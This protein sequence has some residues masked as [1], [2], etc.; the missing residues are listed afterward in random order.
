[1]KYRRHTD[2][3]KKKASENNGKY[4]LGKT[5]SRDSVEKMRLTK[6]GKKASE[7][8]KIKMGKS[9]CGRKQ[10]NGGTSKF[11][12]TYKRN[13]NGK[14]RSSIQ[15]L[16]R[17]YRSKSFFTEDEAA[18]AYDELYKNIHGTS[19]GP[20]FPNGYLLKTIKEDI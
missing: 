11:V 5:R 14:Y 6:I 20:N 17:V 16:G 18:L 19:F 7:E 12:G 15:Y 1:M 8:T 2:D 3:E 4:W 9:H 10:N 13:D